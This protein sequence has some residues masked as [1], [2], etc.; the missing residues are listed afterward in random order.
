MLENKSIRSIP[1][2]M[3]QWS[4]EVVKVRQ[5]NYE[6]LPKVCSLYCSTDKAFTII[7]IGQFKTTFNV[8]PPQTTTGN[9]GSSCRDAQV[10]RACFLC[11][12][13]FL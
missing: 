6:H 12:N 7:R 3:H 2:W 5:M 8:L 10:G 13:Q 1:F 9:E 11:G 4:T